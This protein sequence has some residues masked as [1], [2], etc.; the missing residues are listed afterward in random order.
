MSSILKGILIG[1]LSGKRILISAIR[2]S[3]RVTKISSKYLTQLAPSEYS[4]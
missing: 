2:I 4:K 3:S 1:F